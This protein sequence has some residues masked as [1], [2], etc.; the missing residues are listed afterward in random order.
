MT[1]R[2]ASI[3]LAQYGERTSTWS[4]ATY[5]SGTER[6]LHEIALTL[7]A[8]VVELRKQLAA[9]EVMNPQQCQAG[10]HADWLVDSEYTH[11]CPWCALD[12]AAR[13]SEA[14]NRRLSEEMLGGSAL[15]AALTTPTTPEERQAALDK[16]QATARRAS[17]VEDGGAV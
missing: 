2:A 5:D 12:D 13:V 3:R 9:Y 1:A 10:K 11:A 15:Y 7:N 17:Q 4:T 16:F 8:E 14:L 6:A